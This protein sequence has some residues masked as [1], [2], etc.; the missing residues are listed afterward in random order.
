MARKYEQVNFTPFLKQWVSKLSF[1][2]AAVFL[3]AE[4]G[5]Q[6]CGFVRAVYDGSRALIHLFSIHPNYQHQGVGSALINAICTE[7]SHRGA[8]TISVTVTEKS[9]GFWKKKGFMRTPAFLV[10]KNLD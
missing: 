8:P 5:E 9:V 7:L 6:P 4:M 10:L 2:E 1:C 3:V